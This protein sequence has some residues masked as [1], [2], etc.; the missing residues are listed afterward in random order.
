MHVYT[1]FYLHA[2]SYNVHTVIKFRTLP[3]TVMMIYE[4]ELLKKHYT[5][6]FV[7]STYLR[8]PTK[9]W[10]NTK[11]EY[12][13]LVQKMKN[14]RGGIGPGFYVYEPYNRL[15]WT[16]ERT[17]VVCMKTSLRLSDNLGS[18][19]AFHIPTPTFDHSSINHAEI[20]WLDFTVS[21]NES[22]LKLAWLF[23]LRLVL[24][25]L[26]LCIMQPWWMEANCWEIL[27]C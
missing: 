3:S 18:V 23:V 10:K 15:I 21:Q 13:K 26:W 24:H 16:E 19:F 8:F 9:E 14:W 5:K 11:N 22:W 6:R 7:S 25:V 2:R 20:L 27:L 17:A 1:T 12:K 4:H